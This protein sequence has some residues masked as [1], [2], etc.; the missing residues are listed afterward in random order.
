MILRLDAALSTGEVFPEAVYLE[1]TPFTVAPFRTFSNT[2]FQ[3]SPLVREYRTDE[4]ARRRYQDIALSSSSLPTGTYTVR[5]EV[6]SAGGGVPA[7]GAF[8]IILRNPSVV[9]LL[10]P[11]DDDHQVSSFPLFQWRYDGTRARISIFERLPGQAT[12]EEATGGI[13]QLSAEVTTNSFQYP[14]AGV[15]ALQPG[16]SY[17]W[18]VEGRALTA[19]G[20]DQVVRS[21]IRTFTV[22]SSGSGTESFATYFEELE[23]S[24]GPRFKPVFDQIRAE[25][26]TPSGSLRLDGA[27]IST[28]ELLRLMQLFRTRSESVL[29]V[30]LE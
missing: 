7:T 20:V 6:R 27:T 26:L 3:N 1:T 12:P 5:V 11:F 17:A 28:V 24:L 8:A 14:G 18:F 21:P 29:S 16:K 15:R 9:E 19:G 13:P 10:F 23:R 4:S 30:T 25:H 22:S 2:D